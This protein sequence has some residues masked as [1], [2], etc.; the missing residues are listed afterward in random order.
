MQFENALLEQLKESLS[1]YPEGYNV[2]E[3]IFEI[4]DIFGSLCSNCEFS[5]LNIDIV[6]NPVSGWWKNVLNVSSRCGKTCKEN[7]CY[8][9]YFDGESEVKPEPMDRLPGNVSFKMVCV[10]FVEKGHA[11]R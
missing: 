10:N 6:A 5:E 11:T 3:E 2:A 4:E 9:M 1:A 7:L 8:Q